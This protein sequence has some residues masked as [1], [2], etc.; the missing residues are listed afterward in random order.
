MMRKVCMQDLE[1]I[2]VTDHSVKP[3]AVKKGPP[4]NASGRFLTAIGILV[5]FLGS[6]NASFHLPYASSSLPQ[7]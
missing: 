4:G 6:T 3:V 7:L 2:G 5:F 1:G